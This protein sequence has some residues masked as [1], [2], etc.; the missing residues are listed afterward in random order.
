MIVANQPSPGDKGVQLS[1]PPSQRSTNPDDYQDLPRPIAGM[2]KSFPDGQEIPLHQHRRDQLLYAARGIM[3]IRTEREAW[4]VPPDRAVYI[5]GR[6]AH[7]VSMHGAVE[8]RTLYLE[9]ESAPDL[10]TRALAIQVSDLLRALIMALIEEPLLYDEEG[11][12]GA[13]A[14]LI[15]CEIA[16]ADRL[17]LMVPMPMDA[18]LSRICLALLA[19]PADART[20][21][22]WTELAGASPRTLARLFRQEVGLSFA[23]L[24]QRIRFHNALEDLVKGEPLVRIASRNGYRSPSA[25][26]AAFRKAMGAAPSSLR[27]RRG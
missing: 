15:H 26:S 13:I 20:L 19:D 16:R 23:V 27:E 12:G 3:R 2:A 9:P 21:D 14:S 11:R 4:I 1:G 10:P 5:P 6:T 18:R 24:R 7:S 25:F 17:S 8:M 22:Q